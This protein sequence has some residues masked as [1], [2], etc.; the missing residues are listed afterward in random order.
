MYVYKRDGR[1]E[2]VHFDKVNIYNNICSNVPTIFEIIFDFQHI[3]LIDY[4]KNCK[5]VL[6][7]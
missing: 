5:V 3:L 4:V 2:M 6:W 1:K 7:S